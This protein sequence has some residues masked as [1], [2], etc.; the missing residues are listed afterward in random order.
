M[1]QAS[2]FCVTYRISPLKGIRQTHYSLKKI[3]KDI[4]SRDFSVF[5]S[6]VSAS[7]SS[8]IDKPARCQANEQEF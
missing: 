2:L 5:K 1:W 4:T 6:K 3:F 8:E 7:L